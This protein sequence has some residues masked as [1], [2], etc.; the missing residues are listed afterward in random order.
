LAD[1]SQSE[2]RGKY[3]QLS[4]QEEADLVEACI[5]GDSRAWQRMVELYGPR[6][7]GAIKYF[8]R[9]YRE[10]LPEDD[11]LNVY[12]EV[13]LDL[14]RD[15]FHKLRT[16]RAG[17]RLATWLFTVARRQCLDHVRAIT[18][19]K[20]RPVALAEPDILDLGEPLG[21]RD[22]PIAAG[23]NREAL[24]QAMERLNYRSKLLLILFYFE[25][26]SYAEIARLME[27]SETS[28]S[29]M[30]KKARETMREMLR[31]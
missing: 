20:R 5:S 30:M 24:L 26:L 27:V 7:Y 2:P 25:G 23:E 31:E 1:D 12:Q 6:V 22:D 16:F 19:K 28:V 4:A 18:R 10:S 14:C 17:G 3:R 13:F 15:D 29:S 9:S 11:A 8:L 21:R